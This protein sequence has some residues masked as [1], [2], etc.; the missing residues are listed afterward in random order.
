MGLWPLAGAVVVEVGET[1]VVTE[2]YEVAVTEGLVTL[3]TARHLSRVH[4][5]VC[6]V[7]SVVVGTGTLTPLMTMKP[8]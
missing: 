2:G 8:S 3:Q 7:V 4:E 5:G 6:G 1:P